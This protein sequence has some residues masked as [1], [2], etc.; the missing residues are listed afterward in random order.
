[1]ERAQARARAG[2]VAVVPK[3][4]ERARQKLEELTTLALDESVSHEDFLR[5]VERAVIEMP[6]MME[7][8]D[9]DALGR[10]MADVMAD[11]MARGMLATRER[12][13]AAG[14]PPPGAK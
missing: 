14:V 12:A 9:H 8:L 10:Y 1:M 2:L 4:T 3:W 5:R 7:E 13:A 6:A 11:S